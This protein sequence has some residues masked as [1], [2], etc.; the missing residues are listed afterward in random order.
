[1]QKNY[2]RINYMD[3]SELETV[4]EL[5]CVEDNKTNHKQKQTDYI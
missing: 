3:H 4:S 2:L 5:F 1:M